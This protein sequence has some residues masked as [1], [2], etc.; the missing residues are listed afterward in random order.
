[1][2]GHQLMAQIRAFSLLAQI[3]GMKALNA[4][5]LQRGET[6]AY[7]ENAFYDLANQLEELARD[8]GQV[9]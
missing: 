5:R 7:D 8:A 2:Q 3:E 9:Y 4:H 1:M 6:Q